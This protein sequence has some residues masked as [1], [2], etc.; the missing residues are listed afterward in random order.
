VNTPTVIPFAPQAEI[1]RKSGAR[2]RLTCRW[3]RD[4]Q[5]G[6]L[7]CRWVVEKVDGEKPN[8]RGA[9]ASKRVR[10]RSITSGRRS[11]TYGRPHP[12]IR[13]SRPGDGSS[14]G[15]VKFSGVQELKGR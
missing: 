2:P 14:S 12:K 9:K 13:S 8:P 15:R 6:R 1:K 10:F 5:M 11:R 7:V 3:I 4:P